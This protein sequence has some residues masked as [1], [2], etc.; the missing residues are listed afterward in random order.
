[1]PPNDDVQA[2]FSPL[3]PSVQYNPLS[4]TWGPLDI[5][6]VDTASITFVSGL[7]T[8]GGHGDP[9]AKEGIAIHMYAANTSMV[10][11]AFCNNDGDFLIIPNEGRLDIQ[12]ELG[13]M[14]VK[15]GEIAVI[16][17]GIRWK[18]NLLD[19]VARG[20]VQEI[21][22]TRY[23]LPELGPLGSNGMALP[24]DFKTPVASFNIDDSTW[25]IIIKLAGKFYS[26]E[27]AW[28]PFDV[29]SWHGKYVPQLCLFSFA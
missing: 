16:Q 22:G 12:T 8:M 28:T 14:M 25:T 27:Q 19:D 26:Y 20:Y 5:P 18:V 10:N 11:E 29:V 13:T 3:N 23:E 24:K 9:T 15:P 21:Y 1:M 2:C 4:H 7:K 6:S 17:A